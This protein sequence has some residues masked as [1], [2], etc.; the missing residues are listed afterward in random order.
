M[1]WG[2]ALVLT[3][4]FG[5]SEA[6][7]GG[8]G[9]GGASS[10]SSSDSSTTDSSPS[11]SSSS[12]STTTTFDGDPDYLELTIDGTSVWR[13]EATSSNCGPSDYVLQTVDVASYADGQSH[14]LELHAVT[15]SPHGW[16]SSF[17]VDSLALASCAD[18]A[19]GG[20][21]AGGCA[22][23]IEDP[24]FEGGTPSL[25]WAEE[26]TCCGT[27]LCDSTCSADGQSRAFD[28]EWFAWFGGIANAT[29]EGRLGQNV[30]IP[31]GSTTLQLWLSM[32]KP[33]T[34]P[35]PSP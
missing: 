13:V 10:S 25:V 14:A 12:S 35:C 33:R 5:C 31:E 2:S 3:A 30:V 20:G 9:E 23:P 16:A 4:W 21:G 15:L 19:G 27:P 6:N 11:S 18:G 26:S 28:G 7:D 32:P 34:P 22:E 1:V 24:G 29:E 17:L 8:G